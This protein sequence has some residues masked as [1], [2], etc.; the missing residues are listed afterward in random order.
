MNHLDEI[1]IGEFFPQ[2][3]TGSRAFVSVYA[4]HPI[5]GEIMLI[6]ENENENLNEVF[7]LVSE[8]DALELEV[9][10]LDSGKYRA[11]IRIGD[12]EYNRVVHIDHG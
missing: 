1:I 7:D 3:V 11:K 4:Q 8:G 9:S 10:D 6:N 5:H 2:P 12:N